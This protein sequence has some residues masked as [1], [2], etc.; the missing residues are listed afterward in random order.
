MVYITIISIIAFVLTSILHVIDIVV[1]ISSP[2][3]ASYY[4]LMVAAFVVFQIPALLIEFYV[5]KRLAILKNKNKKLMPVTKLRLFQTFQ[6]FNYI[7]LVS[8]Y[9]PVVQIASAAI[10]I[11]GGFY[12]PILYYFVLTPLL[13]QQLNQISKA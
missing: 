10:F 5:I 2:S 12:V 9:I 8:F 6:L 4:H 1:I 7:L 13:I 3:L 11:S